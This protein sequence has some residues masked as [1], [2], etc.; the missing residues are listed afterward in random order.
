[1]FQWRILN[2]QEEKRKNKPAHAAVTGCLSP[3]LL[4]AVNFTAAA[5]ETPL[6]AR[7]CGCCILD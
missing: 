7:C 5:V 2:N 6:S 3:P 1:M 4:S